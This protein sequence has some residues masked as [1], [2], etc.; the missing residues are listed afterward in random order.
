MGRTVSGEGLVY[1]PG[2]FLSSDDIS[3][4]TLCL[5]LPHDVCN[6]SVSCGD[7]ALSC[8]VKRGERAPVMGISEKVEREDGAMNY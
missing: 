6:I 8:L 4:P 7:K 3:A 1:S 2:S 5:P